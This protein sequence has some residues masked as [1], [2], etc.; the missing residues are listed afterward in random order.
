MAGVG[1]IRQCLYRNYQFSAAKIPVR[2]Q[3][4]L[5]SESVHLQAFNMY[6][7]EAASRVQE[8]RLPY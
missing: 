6:P 7:V 5:R 8:P 1:E 3:P 4:L 2:R